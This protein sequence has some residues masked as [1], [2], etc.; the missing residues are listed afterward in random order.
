MKKEKI[1]NEKLK[2]THHTLT[3][4]EEE[5]VEPT[6]SERQIKILD[7]IKSNFADFEYKV[8][9]LYIEYDSIRKV[10]DET[11][12]KRGTINDIIIKIKNKVRLELDNKVKKSI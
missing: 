8:F 7:I 9:L 1:I 6:A 12:V 10:A 11:N 2:Y 4:I 3:K 5:Y